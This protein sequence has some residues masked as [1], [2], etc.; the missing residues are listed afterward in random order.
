MIKN[1]KIRKQGKKKKRKV[2]DQRK[3]YQV[4]KA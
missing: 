1:S 3:T 4:G 2:Q